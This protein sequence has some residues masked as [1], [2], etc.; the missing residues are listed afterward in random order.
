L[1]IRI[2]FGG[3]HGG[4]KGTAIFMSLDVSELKSCNT[5]V[6]DVAKAVISVTD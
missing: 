3:P 5:I 2:T 6:D 4:C 1:K